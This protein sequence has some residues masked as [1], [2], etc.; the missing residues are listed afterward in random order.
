MDMQEIKKTCNYYFKNL[1]N[2]KGELPFHLYKKL[3]FI[4]M[5]WSFALLL[6]FLIYTF[7]DI[8]FEP[9]YTDLPLSEI[10]RLRGIEQFKNFNFIFFICLSIYIFTLST[11]IKRF[12]FLRKTPAFY[13]AAGAIGMPLIYA[14]AY[15]SNIIMH[16]SSTLGV[17]GIIMISWFTN[18]K[19]K[20][21][22]RDKL[23]RDYDFEDI[24]NIQ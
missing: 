6:I 20:I 17:L 2:F 13:L 15:Y 8:F 10:D 21:T 16:N 19:N 5:I 1:F 22:D 12:R 18:S 24:D 11:E 4:P 7:R 3:T 14:H 23:Y 9:T